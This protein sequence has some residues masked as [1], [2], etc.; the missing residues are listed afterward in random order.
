MLAFLL[1]RR[2]DE[3]AFGFFGPQETIVLELFDLY[4]VPPKDND[5]EYDLQPD[6]TIKASKKM[7]S[8]LPTEN[9]RT[10][11]A[12]TTKTSQPFIR[13]LRHLDWIKVDEM[14]DAC[15][16]YTNERDI[17][18]F[19]ELE[20]WQRYN[21]IPRTSQ[22]ADRVRF[23]KGFRD[24]AETTASRPQL[25][26][27]ETYDLH[28][29]S[30]RKE[31]E[32]RLQKSNKRWVVKSSTGHVRTIEPEQTTLNAEPGEV[33]QEFICNEMQ[34]DEGETESKRPFELRVYWFVASLD[35]LIVFYMDG[36]VRIAGGGNSTNGED[37][38]AFS[39]HAPWPKLEDYL[40]AQIRRLGNPITIVDP[41][42]H[43]RSQLKE[44]LSQL[45]DAFKE[46]TFATGGIMSA[47]DSFELYTADYMLDMDLDIW[48]MK[49]RA[50]NCTGTES[51]FEDY[52]FK[53]DMHHQIFY[54]M[55]M[56]LDEIWENQ[57]KGLPLLPLHN[58]GKWEVIYAGAND[59]ADSWKF[60]YDGYERKKKACP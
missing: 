16:I 21:H 50:D 59:N 51:S 33:V 28:V 22:W 23:A 8:T 9:V 47:E 5:Y 44:S 19:D 24:Y 26:L 4:S 48:L 17:E 38:T 46:Q 3:S 14:Q 27:P 2:P 58:T 6:I 1:F 39:E 32:K 31:F 12:D 54:G 18:L 41:V 56:I 36:F 11:F 13:T 42:N 55:A 34:W 37:S 53:F 30:Q 43:V 52:Y 40:L 60:E 10:F 29:D 49:A 45:V 15:M 7:F 57:A 20:P 25:F 35:P